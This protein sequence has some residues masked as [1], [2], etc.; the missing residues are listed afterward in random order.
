MGDRLERLAARVA[1]LEPPSSAVLVAELGQW[2]RGVQLMVDRA[3]GPADL[4]R[5]LALPR[6]PVWVRRD[7]L[8][9][10]EAWEMAHGQAAM[11]EPLG[12]G[13]LLELH[14]LMFRHRRPLAAGQLRSGPAPRLGR[15][16]APPAAVVP[17]LLRDAMESVN[18][19][20]AQ[21]SDAVLSGVRLFQR[22]VLLR[23]FAVG[24]L[25]LGTAGANLVWLRQGYPWV[26]PQLSRARWL[27]ML[28]AG[29]GGVAPVLV[30]AWLD[31]LE[32][33]VRRRSAGRSPEGG[34]AVTER[35]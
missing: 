12:E 1:A 4:E 6:P 34:H 7:I 26:M 2:I 30:D 31:A 18:Y 25:R 20:E 8:P 24:N 15:L 23:P 35:N 3:A 29:S 16:A 17:P 32:A 14:W 33:A 22:L 11:M 19:D 9:L 5:I 13:V 28:E 10:K 27:E 21:G